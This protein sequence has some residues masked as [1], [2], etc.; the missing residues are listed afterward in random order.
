MKQIESNFRENSRACVVIQDDEGLDWSEFLLEDDVVGYTFTE[1]VKTESTNKHSAFVAEIK[2][3]MREEI[4]KE[5]TERERFFADCK[6]Q[7]M[8]EEFEDANFYRRY[9]KKRDCYINKKRDPVVHR[10]EVMY[11]DVLAVIPLSDKYY[12]DF[13][14]AKN[15]MI[16]MDKIIRDVMIASLMKRDE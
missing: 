11:N 3:K 7:K 16:R 6:I 15:Y 5:K 12:S 9:D 8:H 14:K 4:L 10:R 1:Q 2:E 13:A